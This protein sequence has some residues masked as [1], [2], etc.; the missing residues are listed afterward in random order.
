MI[1]SALH[2]F[3]IVI[4]WYEQQVKIEMPKIEGWQNSRELN[5]LAYFTLF[6]LFNKLQHNFIPNNSKEFVPVNSTHD[7]HLATYQ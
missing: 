1:P 5:I 7:F 2:W 6:S 3:E 4:I